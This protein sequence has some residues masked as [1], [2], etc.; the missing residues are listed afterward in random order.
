[1]KVI[2]IEV[3]NDLP[4]DKFHELFD[5]VSKKTKEIAEEHLVHVRVGSVY[6]SL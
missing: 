6:T 4:L 5:V 2:L 1:M 3:E